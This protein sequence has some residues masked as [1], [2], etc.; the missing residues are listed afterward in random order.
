MSATTPSESP[1]FTLEYRNAVDAQGRVTV[2]S[3]WRFA[4]RAEF[5]I[6]VKKDHLVVLPKSELDRFLSWANTLP[7][8]ERIEA[9]DAWGATT[10]R[11]KIDSAGRLTLPAKWTKQV[12]IEPKTTAVLV[13]SIINFKIWSEQRYDANA[14]DREARAR[15]ILE[16]YDG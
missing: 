13:G 4:E 8:A 1:V 14:S 3:D 10:E 2:P 9:M 5:F 16:R 11:V 15:A 7:G 12:G 6:R